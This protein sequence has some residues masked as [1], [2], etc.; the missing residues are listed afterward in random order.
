[1][2]ALFVNSDS[3]AEVFFVFSLHALSPGSPSLQALIKQWTQLSGTVSA[4]LVEEQTASAFCIVRLFYSGE[5]RFLNSDRT[6][7]GEFVPAVGALAPP[8]G[9][10][11]NYPGQVSFSGRIGARRKAEQDAGANQYKHIALVN[12]ALTR[13]RPVL[14]QYPPRATRTP[15]LLP[16]LPDARSNGL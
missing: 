12:A 1:M 3:P 7:R 14:C 9:A 10:A 2:D 15:R 11:V 6:C 4:D 16:S 13:Q 8:S 5:R